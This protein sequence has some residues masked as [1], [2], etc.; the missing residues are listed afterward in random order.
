MSQTALFY[1][2]PVP[3]NAQRH[4]LSRLDANM[5]VAFARHA[6][7]VMITGSEFTLASRDYPIVFIADDDSVIP[8]ALFGLRPD[9]NLFV[10]DAGE[11][12]DGYVP[13]YVRRYPFILSGDPANGQLTVC[14]DEACAGFGQEKGRRLF[15][16]DGTQ[17]PYLQDNLRFLQQYQIDYEQTRHI[18][19]QIRD[20]GL[21]EPMT[22][23]IETADGKKLQIQGFLTVNRERLKAVKGDALAAMNT[24]DAL[25]LI[26]LHLAS[27]N[28]FSHLMARFAALGNNV[29]AA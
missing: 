16:D 18:M 13:A 5:G 24:S 28:T 27:L 21:L 14:I 1:Q 17:S 23:N 19:R 4:A 11:W 12:R 26:H 3:L 8:V 10:N 25:Y 7:A 6:Q 20:A 9:Q 15:L 29:A 22:A 2:Q